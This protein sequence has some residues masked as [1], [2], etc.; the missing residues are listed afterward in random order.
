[1]L[2]SISLRAENWN[3]AKDVN[4]KL[5]ECWKVE[6][7]KTISFTLNMFFVSSLSFIFAFSIS[8]SIL[9][10]IYS[11][12]CCCA[13]WLSAKFFCV[14]FM[15][16]ERWKQRWTRE[17]KKRRNKVEEKKHRNLFERINSKLW[18]KEKEQ[19]QQQT[20]KW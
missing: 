18:R 7:W 15:R 4:A 2:F 3:D 16:C 14:N 13:L 12:S 11:V 5:I 19:Q 20:K 6:W 1:M 9:S 17:K 8:F 10:L